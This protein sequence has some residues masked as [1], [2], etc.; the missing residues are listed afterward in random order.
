MGE[1]GKF[2]LS[3]P[4]K[5]S[6]AD[7][8]LQIEKEGYLPAASRILSR[9]DGNQTLAFKL[10]KGSGPSGVVLLPDGEPAVRATVLLCTPQAGVTMDGPAHVEKGLNTTRHSAQTDAG[11]R[12]SLAPASGPQGLI[13]IHDQGYA[14]VS[15][16]AFEAAGHIMLQPWGRVQGRL[17]LDGQPVV[18]ERIRAGNQVTRYDEAGRRFGFKS[19]HFEA[20]TDSAGSFSFDK[21]PPGECDIFRQTL[22]FPH[23]FESHE[24]SV[25]VAAGSVTEVLLGGG[26]RPVIGK[27]ILTGGTRAIDWQNVTVQLRLK[28]ARDPGTRPQRADFSSTQAYIE[29]ANYFF[30]TSRAQRRFGAFCNS[31]GSFRLQDIPAGTYELKIIVRGFKPDS[32]EANVFSGLL[33]EIASLAREV[34][35]PE[36][37]DAQS[38]EPLDLGILELIAQQE[39]APTK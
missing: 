17:V 5:S 13:A 36:I 2:G 25:M 32:V 26:G 20:K 29:A 34:T 15:M 11:G 14:E 38:T 7:Y 8:Q 21:V 23:G 37:P 28:T 24:T 4:S 27:A 39:S 18:G 16:A 3:F 9:K 33:P 35:V 30:A 22:R 12:F 6:K 31:D 1:D 10:Q 19:F